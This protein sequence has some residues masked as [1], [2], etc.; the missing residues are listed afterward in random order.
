MY[1]TIRGLPFEAFAAEGMRCNSLKPWNKEEAI[2]A[3]LA[4][5]NK[6]GRNLH[7]CSSISS[8]HQYGQQ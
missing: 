8:I 2:D 5:A 7:H 3:V 6:Y 4:T 1:C